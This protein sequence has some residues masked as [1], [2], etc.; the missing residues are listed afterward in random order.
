MSRP[1]LAAILFLIILFASACGRKLSDEDLAPSSSS[2]SQ[3]PTEQVNGESTVVPQ[4]EATDGVEVAAVPDDPFEVKTLSASASNGE[5]L[6]NQMT[7]TGFAC[8]SCHNPQ[9]E[10]RLVGPGLLNVGS[11]AA[12]RVAGESAYEYI[13]NSIINPNAYVVDSFPENLMPQIYSE[14]FSDDE[15]Y[16]LVAYL[17]TLG[18]GPAQVVDNNTSSSTN[19]Q[20]AATTAPT[21]TPIPTITPTPIIVASNLSSEVI[22]GLARSGISSYGEQVFNDPRV[23]GSSCADCH[24]IDGSE[25]PNGPTLAGIVETAK[26]S[27]GEDVPEIYLYNALTNPDVHGS[28]LESIYGLNDLFNVIS[29]LMTLEGT[30]APVTTPATSD[31]EATADPGSDASTGEATSGDDALLAAVEAADPT[32]GESL[33]QTITSTGFACMNCHNSQS[34]DRLVGP[35][36]LGIPTTAGER[37]PGVPA[38]A[39]IYESITNPNAFVVPDYPE[40]LMPQI[41]SEVFTDEEIYDIIAYLLTLE[42]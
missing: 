6:F 13:H 36:L 19:S 40:N 3:Q 14:V 5:T 37:E 1:K 12:S 2:V 9:S 29:Y 18:E 16:D 42:G 4:V 26:A 31:S 27:A 11:R 23:D 30:S 38:Y 24:T 34:Q 39:Y 20:P 21:A 32:V 25:N 35:G 10:D 7:S 33:F 22:L 17:T 8:A 28:N 41:Y 15:I